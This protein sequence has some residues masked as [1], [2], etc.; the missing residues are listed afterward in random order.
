MKQTLNAQMGLFI[1]SFH[2]FIAQVGPKNFVLQ[3]YAAIS[4]NP[5]I[6]LCFPGNPKN[7]QK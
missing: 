6:I 5:V 1:Q 4:G 7:S 3:N 2:I